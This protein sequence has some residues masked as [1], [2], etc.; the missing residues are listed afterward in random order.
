M[1]PS[2]L[3]QKATSILNEQ[4]AAGVV[5]ARE[6]S[7]SI[8]P[9]LTKPSGPPSGVGEQWRHD[10]YAWIDTFADWLTRLQR[11]LSEQ[12]ATALGAG[13]TSGHVGLDTAHEQVPIL[14]PR[15][16]G[17]AGGSVHIAFQ[18]HNDDVRPTRIMFCC[19]DLLS[20]Q[21]RILQQHVLCNPQELQLG[22]D[23]LE[24]ITLQIMVPSGAPPGMYSG[25]LIAPGLSYLRAIVTL[26]VI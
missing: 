15:G 1:E 7:R 9:R 11:P 4:M 20:G 8:S 22:P 26:E 5:A 16:A 3:V 24:E 21:G 14:R 18:V 6:A 23:A 2:A 13:K 17:Q 10:A 19:T 12:M 25:L